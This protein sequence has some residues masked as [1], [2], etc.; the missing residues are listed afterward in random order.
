M[1]NLNAML[2][3]VFRLVILLSLVGSAPLSQATP[4]LLTAPEPGAVLHGQVA[5]RAALPEGNWVRYE[6]EFAYQ[7][8]PTQT[9]FPIVQ[10]EQPPAADPLALWDTTT[11]TDGTYRLRLRLL[12]KDGRVLEQVVE[13]LRVRNYTPVESP[14]LEVLTNAPTLTPTLPAQSPTPAPSPTPLPSNPLT[15]TPGTLLTT[16]AR[17]GMTALG[18]L[19]FLG[20]LA[21]IRSRA[22][23][24]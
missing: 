23:R 4:P 6:L 22:H 8:D 19:I 11:L 2:W 15:L 5:I 24:G 18:L 13:H 17:G 1:I 20:L 3:A 7:E 12:L 16:L 14:T 21:G 10:S 9:W